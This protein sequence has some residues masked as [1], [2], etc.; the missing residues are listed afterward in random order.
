MIGM[1]YMD[2]NYKINGFSMFEY[3]FGSNKKEKIIPPQSPKKKWKQKSA[4]SN[5]NKNVP[6]KYEPS[7]IDI[8]SSDCKKKSLILKL[9]IALENFLYRKK[10]FNLLELQKTCFFIFSSLS[11]PGLFVKI[12]INGTKSKKYPVNYDSILKRNIAFVPKKNFKKKPNLKF[13]FENIKKEMIIE[14]KY[15]STEYEDKKFINVLDLKKLRK[16]EEEN[17]SNFS[18]L[19]SQLKNKNNGRFIISKSSKDMEYSNLKK[20]FFC[21]KTKIRKLSDSIEKVIIVKNPNSNTSLNNKKIKA[22][23]TT[24]SILKSRP[25]HRIPSERKISFG[26]VEYSY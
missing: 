5:K 15:Y 13:T 22:K 7:L 8:I 10:V 25:E 1:T 2:L 24:Q 6:I 3:I 12:F 26:D 11:L 20:N 16:K 23:N 21:G 9:E 17:N 4:N 19:L 18:E 14:S